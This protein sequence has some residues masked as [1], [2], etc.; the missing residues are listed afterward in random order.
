MASAKFSVSV[1]KEELL[2]ARDRYLA[3]T[4][5]MAGEKAAFASGERLRRGDFSPSNLTPII[6]WKSPRPKSRIESNPEHDVRDAL[7]MAVA[8]STDRAAVAVLCG[9]RG[10]DIPVASAILT[11]VFPDRFTV[12]DF[13]ALATLGVEKPAHT[14]EE[15]LQYLAYCRCTAADCGLPLRDFDRALWQVSKNAA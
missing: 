7:R 8:A 4:R 1:T 13:R 11:A 3:N 2:A 12:I 14:M 6:R 10:V 9:L 5:M 15:Y